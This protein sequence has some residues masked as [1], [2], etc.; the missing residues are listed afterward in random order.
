MAFDAQAITD[1]YSAVV[2]A[3][4]AGGQFRQVVQ[5]EPK[6]APVTLP[7]VALWLSDVSPVGAVSGLASTSARL[8][9]MARVYLNWASKSEEQ[10]DLELLRLSASVVATYT[11]GFTLHGEVMQVDLLGSYG[12]ALSVKPLW[13]VHDGKTFRSAEIIIPLIL[14]DVWTQEA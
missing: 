5:H 14:D 2:S 4:K 9:L 7:A 1:L 11:A 10:T 6:A 3:I 12:D 13:L 8:E